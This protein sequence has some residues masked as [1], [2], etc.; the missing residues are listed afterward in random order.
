M[1]DKNRYAGSAIS[2]TSEI[3]LLPTLDRLATGNMMIRHSLLR[4][5]TASDLAEALIEEHEELIGQ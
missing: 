2:R 3:K 5:V 4:G 1:L